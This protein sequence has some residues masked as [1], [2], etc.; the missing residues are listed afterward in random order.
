MTNIAT[1]STSNTNTNN[2]RKLKYILKRKI[3]KY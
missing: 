2:C 3:N 1:L